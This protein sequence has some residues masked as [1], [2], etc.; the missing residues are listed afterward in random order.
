MYPDCNREP[1]IR[2]RIPGLQSVHGTVQCE[3][4][5]RNRQGS[6]LTSRPRCPGMITPQTCCI[7]LLL[8]MLMLVCIRLDSLK[9]EMWP[10]LPLGIFGSEACY[11]C[12]SR[13]SRTRESRPRSITTMQST[14]SSWSSGS[15][16][17][18]SGT[19]SSIPCLTLPS[20]SVPAARRTTL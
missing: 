10:S 14:R 8:C 9:M 17:T 4:A 3:P 5:C 16:R 19:T 2:R 7:W 12:R 1:G 18:S 6:R 11:L 13:V 15:S 20:R